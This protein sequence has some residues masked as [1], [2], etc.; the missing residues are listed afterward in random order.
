MIINSISDNQKSV[1]G[2]LYLDN[3]PVRIVI[4]DDKIFNITKIEKLQKQYHNVYIAPGLIDNQVNG[5]IGVSFVDTGSE[6]SIEGIYNITNAFWKVGVTTYL[7]TLTTNDRNIYI[8]NLALLNSAKNDNLTRGS[9]AGFH[10]E[11]PYISST[12]GY[13]GAHPLKYIR[14]SD[15]NEFSILYNASGGNILQVTVAPEIEGAMDFIS[16]CIANGIRIGLGHHNAPA[17]QIAE[18]ADRGARIVTHLG[19]GLANT[20]NRYQNPL[21][22]QLSDDRLLIS[23]ICDGFHLLPEQ[24][25]VFYRVKGKDRIIITTDMSNFGGLSPGYYLNEIGDT[26][27]VTHEG[28]VIYPAVNGLSGAAAPLIKG[29]G[30]VMKVTGCD[31]ASAIQMASTNPARFYG[32]SDRGEIKPGKRA[33]IILFTL[34]NFVINIIKTIVAGEI[35]YD[36]ENFYSN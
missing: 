25:V 12:D 33:D 23:I 9:I 5:Y 14:K 4:K 36:S 31:L 32:L 17:V 22:P 6:L 1:E 24:I 29:I 20:I 21:W 15:W 16:R 30:H 27:Q 18:S 13:R 28:A 10:M 8:K 35:V 7:P 26:I 2:L 19:N 3:S 34:N 11:G